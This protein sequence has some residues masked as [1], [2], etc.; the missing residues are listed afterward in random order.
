MYH[1]ILSQ[2]AMKHLREEKKKEKKKEKEN[3]KR[4]N[5]KNVYSEN[6][7]N[8]LF[9]KINDEEIVFKILLIPFSTKQE[10]HKAGKTI[11]QKLNDKNFQEC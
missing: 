6:E 3:E 5:Y 11:Q 7:H 1:N 4:Q 8:R 2:H 10:K 9:T